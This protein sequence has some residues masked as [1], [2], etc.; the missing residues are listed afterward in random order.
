MDLLVFSLRQCLRQLSRCAS[1]AKLII[2]KQQ[3]T[4][5]KW[6]V[7]IFSVKERGSAIF[8]PARGILELKYVF[9]AANAA[10]TIAGVREKEWTAE[11]RRKI[12]SER[13]G[14]EQN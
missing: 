3:K 9:L 13:G 1:L 12:W 14:P 6:P 5:K 10:I 7:Q 8:F 2:R 11:G 4:D